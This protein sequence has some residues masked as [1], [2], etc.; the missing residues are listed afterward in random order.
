[1][2]ENLFFITLHSNMGGLYEDNKPYFIS[3]VQHNKTAAK[4]FSLGI[5][6]PPLV[7]DP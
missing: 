7:E 3:N 2:L 1:M 5:N 6:P 4:I